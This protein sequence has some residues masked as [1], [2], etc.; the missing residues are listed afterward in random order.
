M[1][2]QNL[3]SNAVK[4]SQSSGIIKINLLKLNKDESFSEKNIHEDSLIFSI[5]DSGIGIPTYQQKN[6]FSKLFRADN[7][8][9]SG[10]EGTGLGLYVVKSIVD[11]SGG[12]VWFKS[13]ENKG[14][15][16]NISFPIKGMKVKE[17]E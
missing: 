16:F 11:Q 6:I 4:F 12:S 9:E 17:K 10:I 8:R 14:T 5:S 15:S 13:E 7:A 2:F 1:I 3:I